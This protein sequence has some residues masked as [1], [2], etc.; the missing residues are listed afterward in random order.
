MPT[1]ATAGTWYVWAE[2]TDGSAANAY[3]TP[4]TVT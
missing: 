3:P 2:G 1:P 4:F